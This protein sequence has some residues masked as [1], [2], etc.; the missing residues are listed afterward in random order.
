MTD[1]EEKRRRV[2]ANINVKIMSKFL[3]HRTLLKKFLAQVK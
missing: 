1:F 3:S 2:L